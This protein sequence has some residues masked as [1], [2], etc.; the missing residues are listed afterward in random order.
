MCSI[1]WFSPL[2]QYLDDVRQEKPSSV[3][4]DLHP[5]RIKSLVKSNPEVYRINKKI[6]LP[7]ISFYSCFAAWSLKATA[8]DL[9]GA[10]GPPT[11][12]LC[13]AKCACHLVVFSEKSVFVDAFNYIGRP[14]SSISLEEYL[15]FWR[16][17]YY[18]YWFPESRPGIWIWWM[19]DQAT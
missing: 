3:N 13:L 15:I 7:K 11:M 8:P 17:N 18:T 16:N 14:N 6:E 10:K 5:N 19:Q 2:S 9:G 4:P 1:T 12:F